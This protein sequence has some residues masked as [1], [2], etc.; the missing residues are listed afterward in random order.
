M[1]SEFLAEILVILAYFTMGTTLA[2]MFREGPH[3][4]ARG[5]FIAGGM[6]G[7]F[8]AAMTYAATTYSAF[9]M[10]GLVGFSYM[11]GVGALGFELVYFIG[12]MFL[13]ALFAHKIWILSRTRRWISPAEMIGDLYGSKLLTI[14]VGLIYMFALIPYASAQLKGIGEIIAGTVRELENAYVIGIV[15]GVIIIILWS[16]IAGMWSVA[17]TDAYQGI[18]MISAASFFIIWLVLW[19][20][21]RI[22]VDFSLVIEALRR[23][24]LLSVGS[25]FWKFN[26]FLSFTIPWFFFALTNPQVV[27]R[28]YTPKNVTSLRRML[29]WFSFFGI[30]YTIIVTLIGLLARG[31]SEIGLITKVEYRDLVTSTILS[32]APAWLRLL[33]FISI[34]AAAVSTANSIILTL[35]SVASR[36]LYRN[37]SAKSKEYIEV[38]IGKFSIVIIALVLALISYMRL[39]FIVELSVISS[40]LLLPLA[41]ITIAGILK[42]PKTPH[43][44]ASVFLSLALTELLGLH[45]IAMY[46]PLKAFTITLYNIPLS[47]WMLLIPTVMLSIAYILFSKRKRLKCYKL[48]LTKV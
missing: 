48:K 26:V 17:I 27:Q 44:K 18:L 34:I 19:S 12:T 13:L 46:G 8:L 9:M 29:I 41:P 37:I 23:E 16:I 47:A 35:A 5:Y 43:I 25:G 38:L 24:D 14:I 15:V 30:T 32:Y 33:V 20:M 3:E 7:S 21:S 22:N 45:I 11:T 40:V 2:L 39:G 31:C 10:V 1:S 42:I 28:L 4:T 36:D 6:L